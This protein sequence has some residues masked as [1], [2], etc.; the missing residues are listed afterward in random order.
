MGDKLMQPLNQQEIETAFRTLNVAWSAIP[1]E[2]L[3][4]VWNVADFNAAWALATKLAQLI[5]TYG[6]APTFLITADKIQLAL[7]NHEASGVT[8]REI[9]LAEA[10]DHLVD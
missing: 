7:S 2:G 4:R 10:I 5:N 9:A 8:T 1:G 6:A 3:V